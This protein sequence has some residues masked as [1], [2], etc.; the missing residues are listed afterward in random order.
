[1]YILTYIRFATETILSISYKIHN[2]NTSPGS[3]DKQRLN[4]HKLQVA[5]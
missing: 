4:Y 1:M 3:E 2:Y 5:M